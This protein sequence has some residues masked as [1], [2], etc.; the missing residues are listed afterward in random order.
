M[1]AGLCAAQPSTAAVAEPKAVEENFGIEGP[2]V[3]GK[4]DS[5]WAGWR[6]DGGLEVGWRGVSV[7]GDG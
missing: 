3:T 6:V 7:A 1:P 4:N 2:L 5:R